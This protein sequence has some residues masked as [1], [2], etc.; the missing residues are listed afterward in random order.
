MTDFA[1]LLLLGTVG[2]VAI[3][4]LANVLAFVPA[5]RYPLLRL[6]DGKVVRLPG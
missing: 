3:G 6:I 2:V 5:D 4:F 1:T